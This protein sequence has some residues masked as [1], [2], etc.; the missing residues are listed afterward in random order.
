MFI[1]QVCKRT[2]LKCGDIEESLAILSRLCVVF[3]DT[4]TQGPYLKDIPLG[5]MV[6]DELFLSATFKERWKEFEG[7]FAQNKT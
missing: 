6:H 1:I 4:S 5:P 2:H 7:E 3:K